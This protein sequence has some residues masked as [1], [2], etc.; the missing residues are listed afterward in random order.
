VPTLAGEQKAAEEG[1]MGKVIIGTDPHKAS[2]TIEVVDRR[3]RPWPR[4]ATPPT[5][6]ATTR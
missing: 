1:D 3:R 2:S 5:T 6:P 4:A